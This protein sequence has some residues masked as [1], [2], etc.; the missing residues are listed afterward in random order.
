M[1]GP[2]AHFRGILRGTV[3]LWSQLAPHHSQRQQRTQRQTHLPRGPSSPGQGALA[4]QPQDE[5]PVPGGGEGV[6]SEL[7]PGFVGAC[8]PPLGA[9]ISGVLCC[10]GPTSLFRA[11]HP[12]PGTVGHCH[13]LSLTSP[14]S[15]LDRPR[16]PSPHLTRLP[17]SAQ[18]SVAS[19][20][21]ASTSVVSLSWPPPAS[22]LPSPHPVSHDVA[23][24]GFLPESVTMVIPSRP[25]PGVCTQGHLG[26]VEGLTSTPAGASEPLGLGRVGCLGDTTPPCPRRSPSLLP[27]PHKPSRA[28]HPAAPRRLGASV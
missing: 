28:E 11:T 6:E 15:G 16:L 1:E 23:T 7:M 12:S 4:L 8:R 14:S 13:P 21:V 20:G 9:Q 17:G 10:A 18:P 27:A 26:S 22:P 25:A 24:P 19:T 3:R 5:V 2:C